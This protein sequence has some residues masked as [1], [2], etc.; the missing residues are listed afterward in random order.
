MRQEL[1]TA[2]FQ[3]D[4]P[5]HGPRAGWA[6]MRVEDYVEFEAHLAEALGEA[7]LRQFQPAA[8]SDA[9]PET[10]QR[11]SAG[12][13]GQRLSLV[14]VASAVERAEKPAASL[15]EIPWAELW[16]QR[17][18]V[19]A[20]IDA[21][22]WPEILPL[23]KSRPDRSTCLYTTPD[24][25]KQ[26]AAPWLVR[27]VQGEE[28][29]LRFKALPEDRH[30]GILF[31]SDRP[32]EELRRHFRRFTL[33]WLP[34]REAAVYFRFY[35]PRVFMDMTEAMKPGRLAAISSPVDAF[36][37]PRSAD[38]LDMSPA[39][40]HLGVYEP[41]EAQPIGGNFRID[42][43]EL[44]RF[45]ALNQ[46]RVA[47]RIGRRLAAAAGQG[48]G[49]DACNAAALAAIGIGARYGMTSRAQVSVLARAVLF[50]GADFD[51]QHVEAARILAGNDLAFQRQDQLLK[52]IAGKL[53]ENARPQSAGSQSARPQSAGSRRVTS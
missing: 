35:D 1:L 20:I 14:F 17:R 7:R 16:Q 51:R 34:D 26:A 37:L 18:P 46:R 39:P 22:A 40:G 48:H 38:N 21:V 33:A 10:L 30:G 31:S 13:S 32:A 43:T 25:Q 3:A 6:Q 49:G 15:R 36:Y 28:I 12:R 2:R 52:W 4:F 5:G 50:F 45:N 19:W 23:M 47:L 41:P 29:P 44:E 42:E 11:L 8:A 9:P 53:A 27:M 24:P